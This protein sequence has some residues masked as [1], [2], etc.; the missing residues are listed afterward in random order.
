MEA[1]AGRHE[2]SAEVSLPTPTPSRAAAYN[3]HFT[4]PIF[5]LLAHELVLFFFFH[6]SLGSSPRTPRNH[7]HMDAKKKSPPANAAGA[8][9][10]AAANGYFSTV[11][12]ASPAANAKDAKQT[13]LY[14]MLNKQNSKGQNGGGFADG[15]SHSP[16]KA[17]TAYKDGKHSYPNESSESPY[18]GSSVH[19]GAREFYGNTPQNQCDELPGNH[20]EQNPD[21]SL[22]TRGDW[23]QGSLYY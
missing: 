1:G 3:D 21:G 23:W 7:Q 2:A 17:R 15:K 18:F 10:A 5:L 19:Y 20:K 9:P 11:F 14:A 22:A 16:T 4:C 6:G 13:D 12:S 8:S